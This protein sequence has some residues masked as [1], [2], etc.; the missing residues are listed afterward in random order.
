LTK[1]EAETGR[2]PQKNKER[3]KASQPKGIGNKVHEKQALLQIRDI[4]LKKS[5][6]QIKQQD[7]KRM[8]Q[9]RCLN[10]G[11]YALTKI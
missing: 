9:A 8:Y 2:S 11:D 6:K 1:E 4:K 3:E 7:T 5:G 10:S